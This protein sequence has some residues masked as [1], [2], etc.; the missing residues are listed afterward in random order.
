MDKQGLVTAVRRGEATMLAR[1]EGTYTAT[2]LVVMGDR[3]R[4]TGTEG[5][6]AIQLHRHARG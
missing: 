3:K 6:A 5:R 1:Y 4:F 2:T